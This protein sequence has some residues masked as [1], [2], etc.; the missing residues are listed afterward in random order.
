MID[1]S[2]CTV[3]TGRDSIGNFGLSALEVVTGK[4]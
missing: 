4:H 1:T 3:K 2:L